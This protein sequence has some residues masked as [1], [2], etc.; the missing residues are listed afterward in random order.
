MNKEKTYGT[1]EVAEKFSVYGLGKG[2]D[3]Y[4]LCALCGYILTIR[5]KKGG[6]Q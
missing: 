2:E 5:K 1:T 6:E 4:L 3:K